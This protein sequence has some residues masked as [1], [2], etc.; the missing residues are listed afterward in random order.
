M[1][2]DYEMDYKVERQYNEFVDKLYDL[3]LDQVNLNLDTIYS[4]IT[5][6]YGTN[7]EKTYGIEVNGNNTRFTV[8][9]VNSAGDTIRRHVFNNF[10]DAANCLVQILQ[11]DQIIYK[12]HLISLI[13]QIVLN[14]FKL[15]KTHAERFANKLG[16]NLDL[17][18]E[19]VQVARGKIIE[20]PC[21]TSDYQTYQTLMATGKYNLIQAYKKL[22]D[23]NAGYLQ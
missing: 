13:Q 7:L 11:N 10:S 19:F 21:S 6:L 20:A 17:A 16:Q 22:A 9:F 8:Y 14:K 1:Q 4:V 15:G 12:N 23:L 3:R 5:D 2:H 18:A